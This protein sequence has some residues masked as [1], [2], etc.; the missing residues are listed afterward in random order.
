MNAKDAWKPRLGVVGGGGG[1]GESEF[2]ASR[3]FYS[4]FPPP[5]LGVPSSACFLCVLC[6]FR[7]IVQCCKIP[8][9]FLP[10]PSP[11]GIPSLALSSPASR[12]LPAPITPG[13]LPPLSPSTVSISIDF[14]DFISLFS[15]SVTCLVNLRRFIKHSRGGFIRLSNTSNIVNISPATYRFYSSLLF[16]LLKTVL[17]CAFSE[18]IVISVIPLF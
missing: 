16:S 9:L 1:R 6:L 15:L 2:P 5:S 17:L 4:R 10:T 13:F 7:N 3:T 18:T 8:F 12:T 14:D 11:L